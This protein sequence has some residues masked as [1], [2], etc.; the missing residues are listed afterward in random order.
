MGKPSKPNFPSPPSFQPFPTVG[1]D[2]QFLSDLG[3]QLSL[4]GFLPGRSGTFDLSFL[5]P[6]VT[7]NPEVTRQAVDLASRGTIETRDRAQRDIVN[8]LEASNQLTSSTAV[9]RLADLNQ[10][11]GRDIADIN[12]QFYLADVERS[13]SNIMSL[14][15]G[16]PGLVSNSVGLGQN[17]QGQMND[18]AKWNYEQQLGLEAER[19]QRQQM[20]ERSQAGLFGSFLGPIGGAIAGGIQGGSGPAMAGFDAGWGT[21]NNVAGLAGMFGGFG[22]QGQGLN[23]RLLASR[24]TPGTGVGS[25]RGY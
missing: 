10:S 24:G 25:S 12:T 13:L 1:P 18:F 19:F 21:I 23:Q 15:G 4:G 2:I 11:F 5:H 22:G 14:F 6:L 20:N 8:Q 7:T 16:G 3:R 9:N 17:Q